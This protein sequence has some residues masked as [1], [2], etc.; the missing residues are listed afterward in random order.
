MA[1]YGNITY[2]DVVNSVQENGWDIEKQTP[3][4]TIITKRKGAPGIFAIPLALIPVLGVVLA[5]AWIAARGTVTVTI[6][7]KRT[8]A[9]VHTPTNEYDINTPEDLDIFFDTHNYRGSVSYY[10]V[11]L[12]GG[13]VLFI[14]FILFQLF[15]GGGVQP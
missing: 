13:L 1:T 14:G 2:T 6:E 3:D 7:R 10:A 8:Q 12:T 15:G 11:I 4:A 9:R 5:A